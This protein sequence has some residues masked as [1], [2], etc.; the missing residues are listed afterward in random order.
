MTLNYL[1]WSGKAGK[2]FSKK[3]HFIEIGRMNT[4]QAGIDVKISSCRKNF[5]FEKTEPGGSLGFYGKRQKPSVTKA[6][7]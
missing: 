5:E 7:E 1:I 2:N 3:W 4:R 6:T